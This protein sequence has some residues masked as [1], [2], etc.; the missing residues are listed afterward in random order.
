MRTFC[1]Y[2]TIRLS[3][4]IYI[5]DCSSSGS[6]IIESPGSARVWPQIRSINKNE[7]NIKLAQC[8]IIMCMCVY[9]CIFGLYVAVRLATPL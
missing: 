1:I 3:I 4:C 2:N 8:P 5:S 9:V 7:I 6:G